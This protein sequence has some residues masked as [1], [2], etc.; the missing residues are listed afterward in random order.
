MNHQAVLIQVPEN[1]S[2]LATPWTATAESLA[3]VLVRGFIEVHRRR[4]IC[5]SL[6]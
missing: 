4:S 5:C 6:L 3:D 1:L 2:A